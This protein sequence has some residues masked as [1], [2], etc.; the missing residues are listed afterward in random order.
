MQPN[1]KING[2]QLSVGFIGAGNMGL[3]MIKNLIKADV[4]VKDAKVA[5]LGFPN[6]GK[7]TLINALANKIVART[8][9]MSGFT[10][11]LQKIELPHNWGNK[12]VKQ[13]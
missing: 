1:K 2:K 8:G 4:P 13:L 3:P 9:N 5:I 12:Q 10:K 6:V 11:E 7:S